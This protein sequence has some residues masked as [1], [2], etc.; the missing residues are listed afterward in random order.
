MFAI[1]LL[2]GIP[3]L[4]EGSPLPQAGVYSR[5][6]AWAVFSLL[7]SGL[8]MGILLWRIDA[9]LLPMLAGAGLVLLLLGSLHA[10]AY[11]ALLTAE[12]ASMPMAAPALRRR[13]A[14]LAAAMTVLM[15][16]LTQPWVL[17]LANPSAAPT[18]V[19]TEAIRTRASLSLARDREAQARRALALTAQ[20]ASQSQLAVNWPPAGS[21]P[22]PGGAVAGVSQST[23][24][25]STPAP[26]V[27]PTGS[28]VAM[29]APSSAAQGAPS[30]QAKAVA[31]SPSSPSEGTPV[32]TAGLSTLPGSLQGLA[33]RRAL[34][35]GNG[36]YAV[37]PLPGAL[38]DAQSLAGVLRSLS[39]EVTHI[40]DAARINLEAAIEAYAATIQPGDISFFFFAGHGFQVRGDNYLVALDTQLSLEKLQAGLAPPA[41]SVNTLIE[42]IARRNPLASIV[43]IDACRE[44]LK[45]VPEKGLAPIELGRNTYIA[46]AAAPGR[47]SLED[48]DPKTGL[49]RGYFTAALETYLKEPIDIDHVFRKVRSDVFRVSKGDQ[50]PWS[51]VGLEGQLI[52]ASVQPGQPASIMANRGGSSGSTTMDSAQGAGKRAGSPQSSRA[53]RNASSASKGARASDIQPTEDS[54]VQEGL[55]RAFVCEGEP[56][57]QPGR[58]AQDA[59]CMSALLA[60]QSDDLRE[61]NA[62]VLELTSAAEQADQL[63]DSDLKRLR[64]AWLSLW[65]EPFEALGLTLVVWGLLAGGFWWRSRLTDFHVAYAQRL[66]DFTVALLRDDSQR[67]LATATEIASRAVPSSTGVMSGLSLEHLR[68]RFLARFGEASLHDFKESKRAEWHAF[69]GLSK[70]NSG[71]GP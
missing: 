8:A 45:G 53:T 28:A 52:L 21:I 70:V 63:T 71:E 4:F 48:R 67:A 57:G 20:T 33:R 43:V 69:L 25:P 30:A 13:L 34:V 65:S 68:R 5:A 37:D 49:P 66:H 23:P 55:R 31:Q 56:L 24:T 38:N 58:E 12:P 9:G 22:S 39:F 18:E 16:P 35:I 32:V 17:L 29:N 54:P 42:G 10:Y 6:S 1:G 27:D 60:L 51:T 14:A 2:G 3:R 40:R 41:T 64:I 44:A 7:A 47:A 15:F 11:L 59:R 50:N 62:R 61:A 46:M 36:S 26:A 19:S